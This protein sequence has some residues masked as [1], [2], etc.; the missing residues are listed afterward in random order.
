[1]KSYPPVHKV[2]GYMTGNVY[3]IEG[4]DELVLV[5]TG[6]PRDYRLVADRIKSLG[7]SPAEVGHIFL[8]HF[9]VD[10]A[11]SAAA[12]RRESQAKVYAHEDDVP[13]LQGDDSVSS[14]YRVGVL[15]RAAS[16]F[17][18]TAER[19]TRV[20]PVQVDEPL[21]DGDVVPVL[22]GVRVM[23][24][25]GHTPGST[26]YYWQEK[27][28][29]FTGDVIDNSYLFLTLPT[30]GFSVDFDR[31]ARSAAAVVDAME[32]EDLWLLCSGHGP[33]VGDRPKEKLLKFRGRLTRRGKT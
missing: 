9:H 8:S 6:I 13:Y 16:Y 17:P 4:D 28:V 5:D 21:K 25:P 12:F 23:H 3:I 11:G 10:H 2:T 26:C 27:G 24:A 32:N 20:P 18:K 22:G 15:G 29:L 30:V 33:I 31:A 19:A 14:V 7:R 1:M